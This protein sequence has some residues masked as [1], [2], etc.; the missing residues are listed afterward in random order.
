MH[1]MALDKTPSKQIERN[2]KDKSTNEE[3]GDL[4][5]G[6]Q[7]QSTKSWFFDKK[8]NKS[9]KPLLKLTKER[10]P[11]EIKLQM[12]RGTLKQISLKLEGSLG[13]TLKIYISKHQKI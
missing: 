2:N 3:Y 5:N 7:S 9:E 8:I 12:K 13:N 6:T 10:I 4:K 11:K 1:L